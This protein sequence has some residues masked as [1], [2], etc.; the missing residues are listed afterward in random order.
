[1]EGTK[2]EKLAVCLLYD[3]AKIT[4]IRYYSFNACVCAC[5]RG[6]TPLETRVGF[7]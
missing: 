3:R 7:Y 5:A 4:K 1:M 2:V 6:G